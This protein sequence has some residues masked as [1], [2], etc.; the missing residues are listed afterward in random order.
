MA[1]KALGNAFKLHDI[2][3]VKDPA[4]GAKGDGSTNDSTALQLALDTAKELWIPDGTFF[5]GTTG[6]T[7]TD[8]QVLRFASRNAIIKGTVAGSLLA[9]KDAATTRR[10]RMQMWSGTLDNTDRNTAGG[11]ALDLRNHSSAKIFGSQLKN[12]ETGVRSNAPVTGGSFYN[13]FHGVDILTVD[14]GYEFGTLGNENKVFGGR[15]NECETGARVND[16][17]GHVFLALAVE[18][19][20]NFGFEV[21]SSATS[22]Y[23]RIIAPRLENTGSVGTGIRVYAAAQST[24][25]V[26]PQCVGLSTNLI[27]AGTDTVVLATDKASPALRVA[28]LK[29]GQTLT[30]TVR[31]LLYADASQAYLRNSADSGYYS[32]DLLDLICRGSILPSAGAAFIKSGAGSPEGVVTGPVGS[33]WMRTDGG[34]GT[35]LY[36]KESGAGN[37]GWVAK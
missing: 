6:L 22:Q 23:T 32:L 27:D 8:D 28:T 2:A 14:V 34:A 25:I 11:I 9:S 4:F 15:V 5:V 17:S 21:S 18:A 3:N 12:A 13:E 1:S 7:Y 37:T 10:H 20:T 36:V 30:S 33:L 26:D 29:L 16:N 19:F 31:A 35:T 24:I